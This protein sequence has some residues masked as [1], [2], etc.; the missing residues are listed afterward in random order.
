[1]A[2]TFTLVSLLREELSQL[3]RVKA[4]KREKEE[5]E[6]E[7]RLLEVPCAHQFSWIFQLMYIYQEEDA[8]TRG[9]PVTVESFAAWKAKFDKEVAARR[10]QDEE[11]KLRAMTSKEREEYKRLTSRLSGKAK[12]ISSNTTMNA[13]MQVDICLSAT[14]TWRMKI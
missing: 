8:R 2:M 3:I 6:R 7:R 5:T 1:M 11:E 9:T 13:E 4:K 14:N 10:A 12:F